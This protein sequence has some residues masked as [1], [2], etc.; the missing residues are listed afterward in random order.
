[1]KQTLTAALVGGVILWVWGFLAWVVL[2]LHTSSM[3]RI[4]NEDAVIE[5]MRP[6]MDAKGVYVFPSMP[7]D[8]MNQAAM[9]AWTQK[10][11]RG[12][13]GMIVYDPQGSDPMMPSQMIAGLIIFILTAFIAAWFLARSTAAAS[14]YFSR[15]IFCGMLGIFVSFATHLTAWNWMG[16]P[17]DFTTAM[18]VDAIV[19]WLLAG[20]GIAAIMKTP[21]METS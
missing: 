1:M 2:P 18:A 14:S 12:P 3:H 19:G 20:L 6:A 17:L 11:Q 5:A 16:Y 13:K 8:R 9:D 10:Y 4:A 7:E 15:V 21:K